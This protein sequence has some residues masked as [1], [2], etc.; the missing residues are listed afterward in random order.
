MMNSNLKVMF[1]GAIL[2]LSCM[3]AF[4]GSR[5]T[6]VALSK[7]FGP[8]EVVTPVN[9]PAFYTDETAT[10]GIYLVSYSDGLG[11]GVRD[12]DEDPEPEPI[13]GSPLNSM[14]GMAVGP[15]PV[16]VPSDICTAYGATLLE[17]MEGLGIF[18]ASM[19]EQQARAMSNDPRVEFVEG[20][21]E[22]DGGAIQYLPSAAGYWG[23]DLI[24]QR[25]SVRNNSFVYSNNGTGVHVY[26][27]DSGILASHAEF[28]ARVTLEAKFAGSTLYDNVGHGTAV[29]SIIGG[30][31]VGVS[32]NVHLHS[33]RVLDN[34]NKFKFWQL[35]KGLKWVKNNYQLPAVV[36]MSLGARKVPS[37]PFITMGTPPLE[38]AT[39][40]LIKLGLTVV[41][42]AMN[43]GA[44]ASGYVPAR[45]TEAVT[46]G[47]ATSSWTQASFTNWGPK[48]DIFAPG[49][50]VAIAVPGGYSVDNGTS[51]AAPFV[52]GVVCQYLQANPT[53]TPIQVQNW[54]KSNATDGAISG[55]FLRTTS[56][57]LYTNQ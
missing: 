36:N 8:Y 37:I 10:P 11:D 42:A 16:A 55:S 1:S 19:S 27:L 53:A 4:S 26:V 31:N 35:A 24:D 32:K 44:L 43:N 34:N 57:F 14:N 38:K 2:A 17:E 56:K 51:F 7:P 47:A 52:S 41:V 15:E 6:P 54:L 20:D 33:V 12:P 18:V 30:S 3:V 49:V 22:G 46:V 21:R 13:E 50:G 5:P 48:V 29:A 40:R 23:L 45:V 39:K 25:T 9:D 28:G